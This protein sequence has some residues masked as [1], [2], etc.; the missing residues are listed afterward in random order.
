MGKKRKA[1]SIWDDSGIS[2]IA[3]QPQ[4][5]QQQPQNPYQQGTAGYQEW[6][7]QNTNPYQVG[8]SG[9]SGWQT[10]HGLSTQYG[11]QG[12]AAQPPPTPSPEQTG[13]ALGGVNIAEA[14]RQQAAAQPV[15]PGFEG[16]PQYKVISLGGKNAPAIVENVQTGERLNVSARSGAPTGVLSFDPG[17]SAI[18]SRQ[19][20]VGD[21]IF[22]PKL[23]EDQQGL[24]GKG[25]LTPQ[26]TAATAE[27]QANL[28]KEIGDSG[29]KLANKARGQEDQVR[30]AGQLLSLYGVNSLSEIHATQVPSANG[31]TK[32]VFYTDKGFIPE[33]YGNSNRG[34]GRTEF[35]LMQ[36]PNGKVYATSQWADTSQLKDYAPLIMAASL[37]AGL[38]IGPAA[39]SIGSSIV[40]ATGG[41]ISTG[42]ATA[43]SQAA[44]HGV[45][46]GGIAALSGGD[47]GKGFLTGAVGSGIGSAVGALNPGGYVTSNASIGAGINRAISGGLGAAAGAAIS[48][49]DVS[50][51]ALRG[52]IGGGTAGLLSPYTGDML[53]GAI[54][55]Y[56]GGLIDV[57]GNTAGRTGG[58]GGGTTSVAQ[59]VSGYGSS[60][61]GLIAQ[62]AG[63]SDY[64][65]PGQMGVRRGIRG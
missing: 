46:Q 6:Q 50:G 59:P 38:V 18:N 2:G 20:S 45:V 7:Q 3:Q 12:P 29:V 4:Q 47:F 27:G 24:L 13:G 23:A 10:E 1:P 5:P 52:A 43:A 19:T 17:G 54:G 39:A 65:A 9:W 42:V 63:L 60:N 15:P 28:I 30:K 36:G 62:A 34:E 55:K 32:T 56:A 48:G 61:A 22:G 25:I 51:A 37:A 49:G 21:I 44:L 11:N 14:Q 33:T 35:R 8:T 31:G 53:A 64:G 16:G 58:G 40:G 57:G 26:P 41:A